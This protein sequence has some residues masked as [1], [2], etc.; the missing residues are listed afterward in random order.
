MPEDDQGQVG[1]RPG[2][3]D[4][5]VGNPAH[6]RGLELDLIKLRVHLS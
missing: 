3:P 5:A 1:C 6:G 2:Q 4:P